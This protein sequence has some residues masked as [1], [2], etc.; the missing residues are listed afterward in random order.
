MWSCDGHDQQV[1]TH[2]WALRM[3]YCSFNHFARALWTA[4]FLRSYCRDG[5]GN[6]GSIGCLLRFTGSQSS[7]AV[8]ELFVTFSMDMT[9]IWM[10][11]QLSS[12]VGI[13]LGAF[14]A[15]NVE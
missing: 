3:L 5:C 12:G 14:Q 10:P 9:M 15:W 7:F 8:G 6:P 11:E 1:L 2:I 4:V 13:V